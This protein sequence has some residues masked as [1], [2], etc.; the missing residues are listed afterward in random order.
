MKNP[1]WSYTAVLTL[2]L[3]LT[4]CTAE[5]STPAANEAPV[6]TMPVSAQETSG[7]T[8][9]PGCD[10]EATLAK[11]AGALPY[12][13]SVVTYQDAQGVMSLVVWF[14]E[15]QLDPKAG[16]DGLKANVELA[17]RQGILLANK[18]KGSDPCV[19][20]LFP[21]F[22]VIVVDRDYNGWLGARF[23]FS[24]IPQN[25]GLSD[26]Q[27]DDIRL[28]V[29]VGYLRTV[30]AKP[31]TAPSAQACSWAEAQKNLAGYFLKEPL[32]VSFPMADDTGMSVYVQVNGGS[33]PEGYYWSVLT[34][35]AKEIK[36]LNPPVYLIWVIIVDKD[37]KI[38]Q[39]KPVPIGDVPKQ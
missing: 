21:N 7:Q 25:S 27:I 31:A 32:N 12:Q 38:Q 14:V 2:V 10:R 11:L 4:S 23:P 9:V 35:T 28:A 24:A 13:E 37:G 19:E 16:A 17:T 36:C 18:L 15:P 1:Q 5:I 33:D 29:K 20:R 22:N 30:A 26:A 34:N 3:A 39:L 6:S 8:E